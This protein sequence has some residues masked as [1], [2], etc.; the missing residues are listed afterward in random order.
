[1][2]FARSSPNFQEELA[3]S[4]FRSEMASKLNA[5]FEEERGRA[6]ERGGG[7]REEKEMGKKLKTLHLGGGKK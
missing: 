2:Q 5:C 1:V 7:E 3:V 6:R 4:F